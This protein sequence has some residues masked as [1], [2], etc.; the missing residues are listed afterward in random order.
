MSPATYPGGLTAR[1]VEVL[2]LV[3]RGLTDTQV[4]QQLVISRRTVN[5][6][7]TSIYGKLQ[8]SSR[9]AATRYAL[10]HHLV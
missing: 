9:S 2:R 8:I 4:A 6:H 10:E 3:A 7:L 5:A 1:E